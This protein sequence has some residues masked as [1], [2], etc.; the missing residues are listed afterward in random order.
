MAPTVYD[1]FT[2]APT[3]STI[4]P[5]SS[6]EVIPISAQEP[7]FGLVRVSAADRSAIVSI[8]LNAAAPAALTSAGNSMFSFGGALRDGDARIFDKTDFNNTKG[9]ALAPAFEISSNTSAVF[10]KVFSP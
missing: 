7:I 6:A 9:L 8:N 2:P 5:V 10:S 4:C 1:V 3:L